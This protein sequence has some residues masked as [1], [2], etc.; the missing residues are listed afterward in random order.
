MRVTNSMIFGN[1]VNNMIRNARH[2]NNLVQSIETQKR[3]QRPSDDPILA[4]RALRYRTFLSETEQFIQNAHT[5]SAWMEVTESAFLNIL[6]GPESIM[7]R[8]STRLVHGATGSIEFNDRMAVIAELSEI[9]HQLKTVEMNHSYMGRFVFSG[10]HTNH[11]P[12]LTGTMT[13]G[14]HFVMEQPLRFRDIETTIAFHRPPGPHSAHELIPDTHIL[15]LPFNGL[16]LTSATPAGVP[17]LGLFQADGSTPLAITLNV[18]QNSATD[19]GAYR[20]VTVPL[21]VNFLAD[22]G[23]LIIP[24]EALHLFEDGIVARFANGEDATGARNRFTEGML[25]PMINFRSWDITNPA[26]VQSFNAAEHDFEMEISVNSHVTINSHARDTLTPQLFADLKR[27]IEFAESLRVSDPRAIE[28]YFYG[29]GFRDEALDNE[30][31]RF[32]TAEKQAF[33]DMLY[34]RFNNM[35]EFTERHV[36]QASTEHTRLGTRMARLDLLHVRLEE[37]EVAFTA[38]L[39]ENEDTDVPS[40]IIRKS[41]AEAAFRD[42]LRAIAMT[43]Q[44]SLADFINR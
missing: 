7:H 4:G 5:A 1:S 40:A 21:T 10:F 15:K 43:T 8:I 19:P 31:N 33:Q 39:S 35:I 30:V 28:A 24:D 3:F 6:R 27:L 13:P 14:T 32:L 2:I 37:N 44:L 22:T 41:N 38:L 23:E 9:F 18:I 42:A 25:N 16:D 26:N 29:Q 12:V 36:S 11:P 20:P 34:S 17:D